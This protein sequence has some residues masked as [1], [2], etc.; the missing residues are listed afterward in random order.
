MTDYLWPPDI[1]PSSQTWGVLDPAGMFTSPLTGSV[2]TVSRPGARLRCTVTVPPLRGQDR[3][4]LM[5]ILGSLRGR[6]NR[7]WMPDFSVTRR[8][9]FPVSELFTNNDFSSGTTGWTA[10]TST[11]S[12]SD[13]VLRVTN[14]KASGANLFG[15]RQ[16]V[17]G[18]TQ[19]AP[20]VLRSFISSLSRSG[21]SN[22]TSWDTPNYAADRAGLV[23]HPAK[24]LATTSG[25][26]YP[27]V[28]DSD[29]TVSLA[30]DYAELSYTSFARCG[31]VDNGPNALTHSDQFDNA[32]WT[33]TNATVTANFATA[34]DGTPSGDALIENSSAGVHHARQIVTVGAAALDYTFVCAMRAATRTWGYLELDENTGSTAAIAYF[35]LST[36]AVGTVAGGA[37]WSNVRAATPVPLGSGWYLCAV[38]ARKT[39]A[40]TSL[41]AVVGMASADNMQSYTGDG[42]SEIY[43]WR[44]TLAQSSVPVRLTQTTTTA[45]TGTSQTGSSLYLKGLPASTAGLLL[46]GDPVQVGNQLNFAAGPL[47]SDAAGKGLLPCILPWRVSPADNDPVFIHQPMTKMVLA[48]E[49]ISWDTGP[50][51]FSSFQIE[52]VEDVA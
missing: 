25:N 4:R 50:G 32:A 11:L 15:V 48:S 47:N 5:G 39:N 34:P 19:Y 24:A 13:R 30:G 20:Y 22:G 41:N 46:A 43:I 28:F 38:T 31:L 3:A 18:L 35:N 6:S 33:K 16:A 23:V 12:A 29:G 44:A 8:G 7:I 26:A 45:T 40:A 10:D 42:A 1:I 36:G 2:R 14:T 49:D 21:M 9:S 37:N 52:L 27:G 51:Q 17:S